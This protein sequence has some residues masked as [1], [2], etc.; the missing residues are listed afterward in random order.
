M[1]TQ[2]KDLVWRHSYIF[3][4]VAHSLVRE[5]GRLGKPRAFASHIKLM[6]STVPGETLTDQITAPWKTGPFMGAIV[7]GFLRTFQQRQGK[8]KVYEPSRER[9]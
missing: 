5:R 2:A 1:K 8:G 4:T 9:G 3:E 6:A 7:L